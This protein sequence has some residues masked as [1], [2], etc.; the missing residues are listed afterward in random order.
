[1][2]QKERTDNSTV[3]AFALGYPQ[4]TRTVPQPTGEVYYQRLSTP[5]LYP[6]VRVTFRQA[7]QQAGTYVCGLHHNSAGLRLACGA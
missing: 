4:F 2:A 3:T 1:M 5:L 7:N 6:S